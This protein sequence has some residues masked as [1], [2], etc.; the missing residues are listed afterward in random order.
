[1]VWVSLLG[2]HQ[3]GFARDDIITEHSTDQREI[4]GRK[5]AV[6]CRALLDYPSSRSNTIVTPSIYS[7]VVIVQLVAEGPFARL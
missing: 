3:D 6:G 5:R 4:G 7:Q 1:M 2:R